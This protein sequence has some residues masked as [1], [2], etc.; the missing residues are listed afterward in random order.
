MKKTQKL[1]A[2][3]FLPVPSAHKGWSRANCLP[4]PGPVVH[5]LQLLFACYPSCYEREVGEIN[6]FRLVYTWKQ[7]PYSNPSK[8]CGGTHAVTRHISEGS[9]K[10]WDSAAGSRWKRCGIR[11]LCWMDVAHPLFSLLSPDPLHSSWLST[12]LAYP[13]PPPSCSQDHEARD[14]VMWCCWYT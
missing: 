11:G 3:A 5:F 9:P 1:S 13:N 8:E 2:V 4:L 7:W 14:E 6:L 10:G 12:V